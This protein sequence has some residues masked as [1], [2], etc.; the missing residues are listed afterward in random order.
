MVPLKNSKCAY[1]RSYDE[2]FYYFSCAESGHN[3]PFLAL[4]SKDSPLNF[5]L[6]KGLNKSGLGRPH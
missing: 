2:I 6:N 1:I 5:T 3:L 4:V